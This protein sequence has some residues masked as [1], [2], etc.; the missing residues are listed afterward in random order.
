MAD[1]GPEHCPGLLTPSAQGGCAGKPRRTGK[2][3]PTPFSSPGGWMRVRQ[4]SSRGWEGALHA[5]LFAPALQLGGVTSS[6]R[7]GCLSPSAAD[8]ACP[9]EAADAGAGAAV[10][11][12]CPHPRMSGHR[13]LREQSRETEV[14]TGHS[15]VTARLPASLQRD[16]STRLESQLLHL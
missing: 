14:L 5:G 4:S 12:M 9:A 13:V 16:L 10:S 1:W 3:A 15:P 2:A 7:L 8:T 11:L 6:C